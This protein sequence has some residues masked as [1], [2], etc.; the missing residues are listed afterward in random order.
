MS[1][2]CNN[3]YMTMTTETQLVEETLIRWKVSMLQ[4]SQ[5]LFSWSMFPLHVVFHVVLPC[6]W[7]FSSMEFHIIGLSLGVDCRWFFQ[8][9]DGIGC[10]NVLLSCKLKHYNQSSPAFYNCSLWKFYHSLFKYHP[11]LKLIIESVQDPIP[12]IARG[13]HMQCRWTYSRTGSTE[14]IRSRHYPRLFGSPDGYRKDCQR[15]FTCRADRQFF[16]R[17][18]CTQPMSIVE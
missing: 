18:S 3:I 4:L 12:H 2:A 1:A 7:S 8:W 17:G 11:P 15:G 13:Y 5:I 9:F 6:F 16:I 10:S 14:L